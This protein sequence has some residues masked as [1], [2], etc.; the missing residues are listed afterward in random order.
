MINQL[1]DKW[2]EFFNRYCKDQLDDLAD[3]YPDFRSLVIDFPYL[4]RYDIDMAEELLSAPRT[5]METAHSALV[6][7]ELGVNKSLDDAHVRV[8]NIPTKVGIRD[9]RS[10]HISTMISIEGVVRKRTEVRPRITRAVFICQRCD[11]RTIID[12][13]DSLRFSEPLECE[14][15]MCLKRGPFKLDRDESSFV[16]AQKLRL[17]ESPEYLRGGEQPQTLDVDLEDDIAGLVVPG[18][19]LT[20]TG[21]LRSY[22]RITREGKSPIFDIILE[23]S[24]IEK[25]D[26]GY[27]DL[28]I[29]DDDIIK[30][31]KISNDPMVY[32]NMV[33]SIAPS[34][35][36]NDDVKEA[37]LMQLFSGVVKYLPDGSRIRGDVHV[38]LVGDPGIAKSQ[39]LR[40]A[41]RLAP[42]GI[43]TSGKGATAAGLTAT[44]VRDDF[45]DGQWTLE[46]GALVLADMGV[47][48]VDEMDKMSKVDRSALH[49]AMEQQT[50]TIAKAGILATL[51][52]RCALLGA[53][54]P[55]YGKFDKYQPLAKQIDMSPALLSRFDLI[56]I[57]I[58][59]VDHEFD[60]KLAKHVINTHHAGQM[61]AQLK[62]TTNSKYTQS[63][64][65]EAMVVVNPEIDPEILRKYIAYAKQEI[66]PVMCD[67]AKQSLI[68]FYLNMRKSGD[69]SDDSVPVTARQLEGLVR[70]SEASARIRLSDEVTLDDTARAIRITESCLK[71]IA[72]DEETGNFDADMISVGSKK[73]Q[74]DKIK[75]V[76][77]IINGYTKSHN[78]Y[79]MEEDE[80]IL[81]VKKKHEIDGNEINE[82]IDMMS[83]HGEIL[84]PKKGYVKCIK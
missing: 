61:D 52:S 40:Y 55:R 2:Q 81:Q 71:Q 73:S 32:Q 44:A 43:Y 78:G 37:L 30:M 34:I 24:H 5:S 69:E 63:D 45:G 4:E 35:Y 58:D 18:D 14:N 15:E 68:D 42:R 57:L 60:S 26:Q 83:K 31:R 70:L 38:L 80:L 27:D 33:S 64:I 29:T 9:I 21:I 75:L 66:A 10:H 41:V 39:M 77:D 11:A 7:I 19:R 36:G 16:D 22:Q 6:D 56:F 59:R 20:L 84:R 65:D 23:C 79:P 51:K 13:T 76:R 17:Q 28:E 12:Q 25:E 46:A 8:S 53:A 3:R 49:E 1:I 47:A 82:I 48:A 54:N 50:I 72:F 67:V 74:R 62:L